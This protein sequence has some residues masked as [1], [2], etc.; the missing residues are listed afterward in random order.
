MPFYILVGKLNVNK[1]VSIVYEADTRKS[2]NKTNHY[3]QLPMTE[4]G[5]CMNRFMKC[6]VRFAIVVCALTALSLIA[7]AA[8]LFI[9]KFN[10]LKTMLESDDIDG[11]RAMMRHSTERRALFDK[12]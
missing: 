4:E 5:A 6:F 8:L 10:D 7:V 2:Y 9:G 1:Q 12:K 11:M 3:T